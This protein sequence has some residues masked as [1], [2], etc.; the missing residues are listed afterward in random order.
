MITAVG[1]HFEYAGV[2]GGADHGPKGYAQRCCPKWRAPSR[3]R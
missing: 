1:D 3:R 2:A